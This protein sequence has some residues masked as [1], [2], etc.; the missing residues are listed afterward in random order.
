MKKIFLIIFTISLTSNISYAKNIKEAY[1]A[2]GCF[3]VY[4]RVF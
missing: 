4:G 3:E 2:G 1:F